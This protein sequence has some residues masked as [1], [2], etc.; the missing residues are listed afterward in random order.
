MEE[1][2]LS[3]ADNNQRR[4]TP[5]IN[6]LKSEML[7][8]ENRD[9]KRLIREAQYYTL[10]HN[11]LYRRGVSTSFLKCIPTFATKEVLEEVH[12]GMCGNYLGAR[13]LS[14]MILRAGFYWPTLQ[15]EA[16]EFVKTCSPC[17]KHA[18]FHATPP[19]ELICVIS[20]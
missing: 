14:K 11:V 6:Y 7:P 4:M 9:A 2:V 16:A 15:K 12:S 20:P 5:I 10:M 18:N 3:I 8:T 17:Q 13:A 1:K 19:E